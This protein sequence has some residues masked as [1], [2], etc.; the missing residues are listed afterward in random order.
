MARQCLDEPLSS[1]QRGL[2]TRS[3]SPRPSDLVWPML[4][5]AAQCGEPGRE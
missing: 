5:V 4:V 2:E 3:R 1:R